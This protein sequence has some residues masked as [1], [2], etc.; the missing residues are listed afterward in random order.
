MTTRDAWAAAIRTELNSITSTTTTQTSHRATLAG[1]ITVTLDP[2]VF[3]ATLTLS[4][5]LRALTLTLTPEQVA[6]MAQW[7]AD[8]DVLNLWW[9]TPDQQTGSIYHD[10]NEFVCCTRYR[11]G[12]GLVK[13]DHVDDIATLR[14]LARAYQETQ[15]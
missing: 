12:H 5:T 6:E 15:P 3:G 7:E 14:A 13:Q 4:D 2:A 1:G 11:C 8:K 9:P 10:T